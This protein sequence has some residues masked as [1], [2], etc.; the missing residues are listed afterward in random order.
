MNIF[1]H[2]QNMSYTSNQ[3]SL[4]RPP[5]KTPRLPEWQQ[6]AINFY[7]TI[8]DISKPF[9]YDHIEELFPGVDFTSPSREDHYSKDICRPFNITIFDTVCELKCS[10]RIKRRSPLGEKPSKYDYYVKLYISTEK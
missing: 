5:F 9:I 6:N 7:E 2:D 10:L 8:V 1:L 4:Y 3:K